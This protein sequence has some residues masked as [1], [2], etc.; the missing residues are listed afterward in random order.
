[1]VPVL[2]GL[3]EGE[4]YVAAGSFILKAEIGKAGADHE[5]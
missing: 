1:M 4:K 5:H 3:K 2:A